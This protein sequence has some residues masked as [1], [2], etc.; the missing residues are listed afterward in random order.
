MTMTQWQ[1]RNTAPKDID[2]ML[3]CP[4]KGPTNHERIEIGVAYNSKGGTRHSW[5]TLW[6]Y[7]PPFPKPTEQGE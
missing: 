2:L 1:T 6:A 3:Y 7:V 4:E 5:A